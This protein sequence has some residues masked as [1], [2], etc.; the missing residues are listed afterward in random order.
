MLV[1]SHTDLS[2]FLFTTFFFLSLK[3]NQNKTLCFFIFSFSF[4]QLADSY[5]SISQNKQH[6]NIK[7]ILFV[8]CNIN[9]QSVRH[10]T[11]QFSL[12]EWSADSSYTER[13]IWWALEVEIIIHFGK[14]SKTF[15][16]I[17]F[18][19]TVAQFRNSRLFL[20]ELCRVSRLHADCTKLWLSDNTEVTAHVF[21]HRLMTVP[22]VCHTQWCF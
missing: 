1:V 14:I 5:I 3:V 4:K 11:I 21:A 19:R 12:K 22:Y 2:F 9:A 8:A 10:W 17:E 7:Y 6:K 18:Q 15:V 13:S 16:Y 20:L